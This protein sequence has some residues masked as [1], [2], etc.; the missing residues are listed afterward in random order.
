MNPVEIVTP[1]NFPIV[2][3][4]VNQISTMMMMIGEIATPVMMKTI[5]EIDGPVKTILISPT[6][7]YPTLNS[8]VIKAVVR[9]LARAQV[10]SIQP[11]ALHT[12]LM[13]RSLSLNLLIMT[14]MTAITTKTEITTMTEMTEKIIMRTRENSRMM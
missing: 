4:V 8:S 3:T 5:T 14:S 12:N 6:L 13:I 2:T 1:V 9:A 7:I 11:L 10:V